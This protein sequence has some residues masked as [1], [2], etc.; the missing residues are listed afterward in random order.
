MIARQNGEQDSY[1]SLKKDSVEDRPPIDE[2]LQF[3][4]DN[5]E[6]SPALSEEVPTFYIL[7]FFSSLLITFKTEKRFYLQ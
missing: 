6:Y 4:L 1:L 2:E 3:I 7:I 5:L